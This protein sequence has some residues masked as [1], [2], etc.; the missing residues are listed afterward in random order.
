MN[1]PADLGA[2]A[3]VG[4]NAVI[5]VAE[6]L[7][8]ARGP[9]VVAQVFRAAGLEHYLK[10]PPS[11]MVDEFEV[12]R[13]QA[14][15]REHLGLA[16]A[17]SVS[18]DAGLRTGDYLLANRI[19]RPVQ[20]LLVILPARLASRVL[21]SAIRRNAWTFVGSGVFDGKPGRPTRL[22]VTDG[23]ICRGASANEP[24]CDFYAG[25][26]ERLFSR[27]VHPNARVT[28]VA[29]QA[30]GDESCVFEVRW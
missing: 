30:N 21:I 17:R 3:R 25:S 10:T 22:T 20:R 24:L 26:F 23:P 13:L 27:L 14:A 5:R 29:C 19:P 18:H 8:E 12:T 28:E 11:E 9:D 6:A 7:D 2:T 1:A 16:E 15:L 4:P